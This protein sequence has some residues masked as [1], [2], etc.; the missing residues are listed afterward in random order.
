MKDGSGDSIVEMDPIY[1]VKQAYGR[2]LSNH[3]KKNFLNLRLFTPAKAELTS[4]NI[5]M[6]LENS[7]ILTP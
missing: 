4:G 6:A 1:V 7:I 3:T 5:G 2:Q